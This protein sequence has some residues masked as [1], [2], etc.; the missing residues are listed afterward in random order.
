LYVNPNRD[1][2][3]RDFDA[4]VNQDA[5]TSLILWAGNLIVTNL[6]RQGKMLT[7]TA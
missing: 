1:F 7:I 2:F 4:P 3:M 5:Y 6:L